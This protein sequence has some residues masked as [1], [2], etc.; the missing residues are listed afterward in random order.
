MAEAR[1]VRTVR[2]IWE[3]NQQLEKSEGV[4]RCVYCGAREDKHNLP[5]DMK[6]YGYEPHIF[7][8]PS[9]EEIEVWLLGYPHRVEL[10][11]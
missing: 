8:Y 3:Y 2:E 5:V 9:R 6:Y 1:V 7:Q 4:R 11:R 10:I